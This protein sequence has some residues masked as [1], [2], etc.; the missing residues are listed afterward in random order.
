MEKIDVRA[1]YRFVSLP[2]FKALREPLL[3]VFPP[4]LLKPSR[5]FSAMKV[6][7][8]GRIRFIVSNCSPNRANKM[9]NLLRLTRI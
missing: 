5:S 4:A 6:T 7:E 8:A 3:K 2:D 9:P 1:F